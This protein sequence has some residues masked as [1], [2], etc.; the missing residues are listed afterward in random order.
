MFYGAFGIVEDKVV[1]E[2]FSKAG[3]YHGVNCPIDD[4]VTGL[5]GADGRDG[6]NVW[7]QSAKEKQCQ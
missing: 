7:P 4:G 5:T 6:R 1:N 3:Q 2:F